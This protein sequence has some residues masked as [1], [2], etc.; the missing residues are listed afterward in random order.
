[1]FVTASLISRNSAYEKD[2]I[3]IRAK[4]CRQ[5]SEVCENP[6]TKQDTCSEDCKACVNGCAECAEI[7]GFFNLML[8]GYA[9]NE[10]RQC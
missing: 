2:L 6:G 3:E 8:I 1:M 5:C 4:A 7:C 10:E 9:I